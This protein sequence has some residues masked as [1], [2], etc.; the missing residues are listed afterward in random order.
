[1]PPEAVTELDIEFFRPLAALRG[2]PLYDRRGPGG[3]AGLA[4]AVRTGGCALFPSHADD[5]VIFF[6]ALAAQC[7]DRGSRCRWRIS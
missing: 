2:A 1:M 4:T 5:D 6:G 3:R 7:V